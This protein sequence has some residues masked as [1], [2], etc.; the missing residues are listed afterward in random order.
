MYLNTHLHTCTH[1]TIKLE[2]SCIDEI[3]AGRAELQFIL[4][5]LREHV[6]DWPQ[7]V[8]F[9]T[10][11]LNG[12]CHNSPKLWQKQTKPN[13]NVLGVGDYSGLSVWV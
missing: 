8:C 5:I 12:Q 7:L 11:V 1:N 10:S 3:Y 9:S 4:I 13:Q 2:A 6:W